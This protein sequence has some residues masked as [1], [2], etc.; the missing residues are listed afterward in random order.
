MIRYFTAVLVICCILSVEYLLLIQSY[1]AAALQKQ[2]EAEKYSCPFSADFIPVVSYL[3]AALFISSIPCVEYMLH[4]QCCKV[5]K[6]WYMIVTEYALA[7]Y[8]TELTFIQ[9][10][11]AC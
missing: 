7:Q 8:S 9:C 4:M 11:I 1:K 5:A 6:V 3:I 2:T 10:C